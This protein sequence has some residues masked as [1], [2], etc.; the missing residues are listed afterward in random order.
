MNRSQLKTCAARWRAS[1]RV[2]RQRSARDSE[3]STKPLLDGVEGLNPST[4]AFF[5]DG[6]PLRQELIHFLASTYS[7]HDPRLA[8]PVLR[9]ME[10]GEFWEL[11]PTI[12]KEETN[13]P[14]IL[15]RLLYLRALANDE[16]CLEEIKS[17]FGPH[18]ESRETPSAGPGF[19]C[20]VPMPRTPESNLYSRF[21]A[22]SL[23]QGC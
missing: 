6:G 2:I 4:A 3:P 5:S 17:E 12:K 11:L 16:S 9:M 1:W 18:R 10:S 7:I 22:R 8:I 14:L 19:W 20:L 15:P 13:H 21:G 23:L